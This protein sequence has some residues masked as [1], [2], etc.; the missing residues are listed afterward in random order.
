MRVT[1][2]VVSDAGARTDVAVNAPSETVV[3]TVLELA[4]HAAGMVPAS[5]LAVD[6]RLLEDLE[7]FGGSSLRDGAVV[8]VTRRQ[9]S[10]CSPGY[11]QLRVIGG[12]DAGH[13][14]QL[15]PGD[16]TLGRGVSSGVAL[17]DPDLSR[18]HLALS[19]SADGV[20]VRDTGSTNGSRLD[21]VALGST[22]VA[23]LPGMRLH[24]GSSTLELALATEAGVALNP[25][26]DNQL[27]YNRPPR[28]D[29][30]DPRA[31]AR[32]VEFP[33][34]PVDR[35]AIRLPLMAIIA[36]LLMGTALAVITRRPEYLLFTVLSPVMMVGQWLSDRVGAG[37]QT[38]LERAA[39]GAKLRAA[40][41]AHAAA[42]VS[43]Q[44]QRRRR[45]PDAAVL[46]SI[47]QAPSARLWER[48]YDNADFLEV[49]LGSGL[50]TAHLQ[51][52][53]DLPVGTPAHVVDVP[54]TV[55]LAD[56]GVLGLAGEPA[57][58]LATVRF[59][60][61]QL[62]ILHSPRDLGLV[63][64]TSSGR[65]DSWDWL[66]WLPHL[67]PGS[68]AAC[69]ALVGVDPETVASRLIEL[70]AIIDSR[71]ATAPGA[72][73]RAIVVIV[74][75]A[76]ALRHTAGLARL[77]AAGPA[78]GV[79]SIC[80][81]NDESS[82]PEES[83]AVAVTSGA[84]ST[85][86]RLRTRGRSAE[87]CLVADGVDIAWSER[88]ARALA[89]LRDDTPGGTDSLPD[90][91]RWSELTGIDLSSV[92]SY[93]G[94][95]WARTD[96]S[97]AGSTRVTIGQGVDGPVNVDIARD[98]PHALVAGT[99]G[100]G[101]S[102]LL[103]T[104]VI[105]LACANRPDELTFV[106]IDYKGGAAF[107]ACGALPHTVGLVTD[108]DGA[109]VE[110]AL[111]S[112]T[113]ELRRRELLLA[114]VGAADI[115]DYRRRGARLARLVIVVDEFAALAD[116]LPEFVNGLVGI[117]QRGRSLGVH[118]I[119]AT[120]RPEGV[121]SAD[122]RA[123]TN[124]RICL[125][126]TRDAESRDVIDTADAARI[127]RTTPGRG[128]LRTGHGELRAFQSGRVGGFGTPTGAGEPVATVSPF[129][130]LASP[131][132]V[133]NAA[134]ARDASITA[135]A[136][137]LE[138][139]VAGC[140]TA[141]ADL[142]ISPTASPWL[143][144]LPDLLVVTDVAAPPTS[145]VALLGMQD[146]PGDQ[147]RSALQFDLTQQGHLLIAGSPRSGRTTVLR[148][149]AGTLATRT[150]LR[151]VHLYG[152]DCGGGGLAAFDVLPHCGGVVGANEPDRA[153][154]LIAMLETE[155]VFR[156]TVLATGGF[157]SVSE[158]RAASA[159]PLP[160]V[161]LA[162]D[163]WESFIS[164]YE[165]VNGGTVLDGVHRLLREGAGA[166]IHLIITADR[167]GLIGRLASTIDNRLVLR[168]ADRTD[169]SLIGLAVRS[170]PTDFAAG[171]G[172]WVDGLTQTQIC[173]LAPDSS[174]PAQR[175]ALQAI[176]QLAAA[177]DLD[178]PDE[179][180]PRRIDAVPTRVVWAQLD[181]ADA[182]RGNAVV[183]LGIGGDELKPITADLLDLG[184]GFV[185]SGPPRSG[186]STAL[187]TIAAN[188]R[189]TGWNVIAV[190]PRRS[191]LHEFADHCFDPH[192]ARLEDALFD[193]TAMVDNPLYESVIGLPRAVLVDDAE[194]VLDSPA[195]NILD[196]YMRR[197]RDTG[198]L[199]VIAGT[200]EDLAIGFRGFV[201]DARR[202]R[203]GVL[204]SPR[205]PLD[206]ELLGVRLPRT[207]GG[208]APAGRG[209]AVARG[210]VTS[211]QV[212]LPA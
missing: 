80:L 163:G 29:A 106:L 112:L 139:I 119:L 52:Q 206:G 76:R 210:G 20:A 28:L 162:I 35:P 184:P 11:L 183:T 152:I 89:P 78:V 7:P 67:R 100:A 1:V 168:L 176:A 99:T 108:L 146:R 107:G 42:I 161:L 190:T 121:V 4:A 180:R 46:M 79:F 156:Q 148:T 189:C 101:K 6:G 41:T 118:L 69:D 96:G 47:S 192:D 110:R 167:A 34:R 204:L 48:R 93:L 124:L 202:S 142:D 195:A 128:Y 137:D 43:E 143:A 105:A 55:H 175:A 211:L 72:Q 104:L 170:L 127:S 45:S 140:V 54:I 63:V 199:L 86:M 187:A 178:A 155:L 53:G 193:P 145:L 102:E 109:L 37:K 75:G 32:V 9:P 3:G 173:L 81:D 203:S 92:P 133:A 103:Q 164:A 179:L 197:A 51:A 14:H 24:A 141:A 174:G 59:L 150:P 66:R 207:G 191:A 21:G 188:L 82:L 70:T 22:A 149:L 205:G 84:C 181:R 60:I 138:S 177:R 136:S 44:E 115:D 185:V 154:R 129:R 122:I 132:R 27:A 64:L 182:P 61:G 16:T 114:S 97:A 8:S 83:G 85:S 111:L 212:A 18:R 117:A 62:V 135:R 186:R 147:A 19:V 201:V 5:R 200:T 17:A 15:P 160:H 126:V 172:Y 68:G 208:S 87:E 130:T 153:R 49:R 116:E 25:R 120:Q 165:D 50:S 56:V 198:E 38:R 209:L 90:A 39:Y 26:A 98:G 40:A 13:S 194:L 171:R 158:Q 159:V 58:I 151:D 169:F 31:P 166:G 65:A 12:P 157:G 71:R 57:R 144:P 36:P 94:R 131:R 73:H 95:R 125:A 77:L 10:P 23:M 134:A 123:N 91:I 113:A 196:R 2:T 74:D 30:P 33:V 88:I